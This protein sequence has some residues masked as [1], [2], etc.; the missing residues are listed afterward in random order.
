M[1]KLEML[2]Q[3]LQNM[4][5]LGI[6]IDNALLMQ[7]SKLEEKLIKEEVLPSLTADIAPKLA[8]IRRDLVLVV[9]YHPGHPLSVALSRKAKISEIIDAKTLTPKVNKPLSSDIK[10]DPLAPHAPVKHVENPTQGLRVIFPDGTVV[11]HAT[12]INTFIAALRLIGLER[13]SRV[14]IM[15]SGYNLVSKNPRPVT[16]GR[17]WQHEVDGWYVFSNTN[18]K[19]KVDDLERISRYYKLG[20]KITCCKP[21][22]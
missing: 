12:A 6:E 5:D 21:A 3:A 18:N 22:K 14:G 19:T 9:E 7:T 10:P 13:V 8:K 15:H 1:T 11:W 4:R 2:Y 16:P 17:V 20:L